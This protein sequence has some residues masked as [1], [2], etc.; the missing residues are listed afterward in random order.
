MLKNSDAVLTCTHNLC[1]EQKSEKISEFLPENCQLLVVNFSIYL[2]R[3]VFEMILFKRKTHIKCVIVP[4]LFEEKR[5][6]TVFGFPWCVVRGAW[7]V[8][9]NF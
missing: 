5:T 3:R 1:F 4:R 8:V 2:N 6:D 9:P 7:C